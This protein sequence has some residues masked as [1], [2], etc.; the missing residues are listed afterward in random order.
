MGGTEH[1]DLDGNNWTEQKPTKQPPP[2][3]FTSGAFD[4]ALNKVV[5]FGGGSV[6]ADQNRTW[7]WD[8]TDWTQ[9]SPA[10]RPSIRE[11]L[12]TVWDPA[13]HQFLIFGGD[14]FNTSRFTGTPGR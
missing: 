6:G 7:A 13:S 14:V 11:G 10:K 8:G 5:V 12:G 9:L 2:L 4:P 3:Y 1:L